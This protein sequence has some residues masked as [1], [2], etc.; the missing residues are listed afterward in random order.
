M[1]RF[2]I[3]AA[4]LLRSPPPARLILCLSSPM[5]KIPTRPRWCSATISNRIRR[6]T[7]AR[8]LG[9]S[10]RSAADSKETAVASTKGADFL[11]AAVGGKGDRV[12]YGSIDY[13]VMQ[14]GD[15]KPFL[16][17]YHAKAVVGSAAKATKVGDA[18]PVEF[19][20][21]FEGDKFKFQFLGKGKPIAD[22]EVTVIL[23]DGKGQKVKTDKDGFTTPYDAKG[24]YGAWTRYF[25]TT[26]GELEGK[27]YE[28]VRHYATV[29]VDFGK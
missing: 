14:K 17:K 11:A 20:T 26:A 18:L 2:G 29:V 8:S 23:P 21:V 7:L 5:P 13:G 22:A 12:I 15:S 27:K 9:S 10:S 19:I 28:E 25:E 6:W 24:R 3:L 4:S 16:L 1:I